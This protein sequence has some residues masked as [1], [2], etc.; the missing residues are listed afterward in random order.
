MDK[1]FYALLNSLLVFVVCT[2]L[3]GVVDAYFH[4]ASIA[5]AYIIAG[6][7]SLIT[8]ILSLAKE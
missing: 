2:F 3:I 8:F 7:F 1:L 6:I 5:V 4:F